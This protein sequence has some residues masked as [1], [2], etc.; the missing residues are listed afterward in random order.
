MNYD[1]PMLLLLDVQLWYALKISSFNR[2]Q[3]QGIIYKS[4]ALPLGLRRE[5]FIK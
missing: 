3:P 1:T 2:F 5:H 4:R